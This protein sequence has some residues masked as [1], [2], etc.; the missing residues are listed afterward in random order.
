MATLPFE[1][2]PH[3]L[4]IL[5]DHK[6]LKSSIHASKL[7]LPAKPVG[8]E[9]L[10]RSLSPFII[11]LERKQENPMPCLIALTTVPDHEDNEDRVLLSPSLLQN[12]QRVAFTFEDSSLLQ[13]IKD[14]QALDTEV[15][16]P[17]FITSSPRNPRPQKKLLSPDWTVQDGLTFYKG[18]LYVPADLNIRQLI[19]R[20]LHN[21]PSVGHP[22]RL[23]TWD[24]VNASFT[25][26]Y[27]PVHF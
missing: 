23:K 4:E 22:G 5:S 16:R 9:F 15:N 11:S 12:P 10:S 13:H 26:W 24:L 21:T 6:N 27:L 19:I 8:L 7:V 1:G 25:A 18:R 14:C 2:S 20:S 3:Q 17:F